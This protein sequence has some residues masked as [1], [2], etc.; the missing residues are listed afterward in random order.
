MLITLRNISFLLFS[1][2][3]FSAVCVQAADI[4][5]RGPIP[6]DTFDKDGNKM[7][8]P[9]EF[10]EA[11]NER[12]KMREDA[13]MPSRRAPRSFTYFDTDGDN[14][15]SPDELSFA[16]GGCGG[17]RQAQDRPP[18][19]PYGQR[20]MGMGRGMGQRRTPP[21]FE[22]FDLNGDGALMRE[23][24]YEARGKRMRERAEQGYSMRN[25]AYA[26]PFERVDVDRDG[27]ITPQ[28]F[29]EYQATHQA[30]RRSQ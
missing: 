24:F 2:T 6:F 26:P 25:A 18:A 10:V 23:E 4:P 22:D 9:Q 21:K 14:Q 11:H 19:G 13:N 20:P 30:R 5:M 1:V 3:T 17:M 27:K 28:E 29:S 8:S 16:R 7:I 15:I 12:K